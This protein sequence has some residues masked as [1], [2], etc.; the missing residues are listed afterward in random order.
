MNKFVF[1]L[2]FVG[3]ASSGS[4][5]FGQTGR[6]V[7]VETMRAAPS[8]DIANPLTPLTR[9]E[10]RK[11]HQII[12][13]HFAEPANKLP[14]DRLRIP[15]LVL[16]EPSKAALLDARGPALP[17]EAS[18]EIFHYP[19]NRLWAATVDLKA[20][21]LSS[22]VLKSTGTQPAVTADEFVVADAL[23][24]AYEPWKLAMLQRGVDP[25][26][27]YVDVWA[28]G[29]VQLPAA[30]EAALPFG[31]QTRLL[32][33]L[34]FWRNGNPDRMNEDMPHNPYDRAIEGVVVT[35]DMNA[36][37]VVHMTN[38][39]VRPVSDESGNAQ[40]R[41]TDL[42]PLKV[43]Q[44]S[45]ASFEVRGQQV[46]WQ[47]WNF[48][49]YLHPRDGLVLSDVRYGDSQRIAH[50]MSLSDI[51]VPY[52]VGDENWTWRSAFDV[53][54]Y[55]LG[56]YAQSL[57]VNAD[58]PENTYFLDAVFSSDTGISAGNPTGT[59]DYPATIGLYERAGGVLWTR[60]DPTTYARDTR[61]ARELVATWNAWI[62]NYIYAF[63]W[64]FKMDGSIE[65]QTHLTGTTL[66]R[67]ADDS[68]EEVGAP[69]LSVSPNGARVAAP[70]HQHFFNFRLDLDV[71]GVQNRVV[72]ENIVHIEQPGFDNVFDATATPVTVEGFHDFN[73]STNRSW[74]VES[75]TTLNA[76]GKP[77]AYEIESTGYTPPLSA[78]TYAPLQRAL[79]AKHQVW[80]TRY[81]ENERYASGDYPNQGPVGEGLP[82]FISPAE[83]LGEG[84]DVVVWYT[85]GF[86]HVPRP[87]DFPVMPT[88]SLSFK[89]S[90]SG[91]FSS[92][93][94]LDAPKQ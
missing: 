20:G 51:Y 79:F 42:K 77:T 59:V 89:I 63:D 48:F 44:P 72:E 24:H 56:A 75:A 61:Y 41:R 46:S 83:A 84:D 73:I 65:V 11:T 81:A 64:I 22:L 36:L 30:T 55:N 74:S 40:V 28:P 37:K 53:G 39:L 23:V 71:N 31:K 2:C 13:A 35:L 91:F 26:L 88:G 76:L 47:K 82:K 80:V 6:T 16:K 70:N 18:V 66:N 87:E 93:P 86:T 78:E 8:H 33:A 27:V 54:E 38:T 7:R 67:G 68:L 15:I 62:G 69:V 14:S 3:I 43:S 19:T 21:T 34:A 92:N 90:P 50:R 25:A 60:T 58:V 9:A 1:A 12:T 49:I 94:A 5:A 4:D 52:G 32:Q 57:E 85:T 10:I 45:G 29:D 17:R